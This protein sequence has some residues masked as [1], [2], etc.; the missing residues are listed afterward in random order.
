MD[1]CSYPWL[2]AA[3]H[4]LHRL[5][6]PRHSPYALS[7]LTKKSWKASSYCVIL[8]LK[9]SSMY[10]RTSPDFLV[11]IPYN[12]RFWVFFT[13]RR[14]IL[15]LIWFNL[16]VFCILRFHCFST[17]TFELLSS[18]S[19]LPF[20][21]YLYIFQCAKVNLVFTFGGL[22]WN[23]TIDLTLIRRAL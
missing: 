6:V 14:L 4:V 23:R 10:T 20:L 11:W 5:L 8:H 22:K 18:S 17:S 19:S 15:F 16:T 21:I 7:S 2:F 13:L 9:N 3:Y 12:T 1:I